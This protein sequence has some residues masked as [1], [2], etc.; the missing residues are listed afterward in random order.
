MVPHAD[1]A[2]HQYTSFGGKYGADRIIM[3]LPSVLILIVA[4]QILNELMCCSYT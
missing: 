1:I 2:L 4:D 3:D